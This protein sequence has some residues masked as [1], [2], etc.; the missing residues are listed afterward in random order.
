MFAHQKMTTNPMLLNPSGTDKAVL[1]KF[2][3]LPQPD[4]KVL[5]T[6]VWIDGTG[7]N[8]RSKTMTIDFEPK[9][10]SELPWWNFDG[11]STGQAQGHNS[12]V[13]IRPCAIFRDPFLG[14]KN[15][16][17]IADTFKHDKT[18]HETNKRYK[19][20]DAM[21]KSANAEPWF[22]LEQE[23]SLLD[24]DGW[25]FGWPKVSIYFLATLFYF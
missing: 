23:Y 1:K 7:E 22:G 21:K 13:F 4:D 10:P 11:S 8:C 25:P 2:L 15:K 18:P 17:V 20:E 16:L 19:C 12:D 5:I 3:D 6:Y 9:N 14:G 24:R